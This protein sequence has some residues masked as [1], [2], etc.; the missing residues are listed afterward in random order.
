[1]ETREVLIVS[2]TLVAL[3]TPFIGVM[4]IL[5]GEFKPQRTTRALVFLTMSIFLGS[6]IAQ[7]DRSGIYFATVQFILTAIIF[8]LSL[9]YGVGGTSR[10]DI[11]VFICA[12]AT[13]FAWK[14]TDNA[15]LALYLS[16]LTDII[17][18]SPTLVKSFKNPE[19]E[20]WK[21]YFSDTIAALLTL[22]AVEEV[23]PN[24]IAFPL[25]I[26]LINGLLALIIFIGRNKLRS[27]NISKKV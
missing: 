6:L 15:I 13:L 17:A 19:T 3:I 20:E 22:I 25:Y 5:K 26:F 16:I 14:T 11:I 10:T 12:M 2:S 8:I 24:V 9:K 1:M 27:I 18:I 23:K 4:A 21:F 7:E